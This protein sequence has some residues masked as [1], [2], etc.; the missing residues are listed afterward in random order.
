V[1]RIVVT[2]LA[3]NEQARIGAC[4]AGL[5]DQ[6]GEIHVV[7]NGSRDRTAEIARGFSGV[8]VH[9]YA[10][11]GKSR[12]WS[13]FVLDETSAY[14]DVHVFVDGDA[15]IAPG[16]V[17]ALAERLMADRHANACAGLPLNGRRAEF[18]R[19]QV[20][21]EHG[22]FGDLYALKGEFLARMKAAGI[23]LPGDLIG[24]DG[25]IGAMA[26]TDLHD[27][28]QW[29]ETRIIACPRAGWLCEPTR[30]LSP[31][32]WRIQYRRMINY[33]VRHFQNRIVSDIMRREGPTGLPRELASLYGEWLM[34]FSPRPS[35]AHWWFDRLALARMR[36][37]ARDRST[38]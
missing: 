10:E 3:H 36:A 19:A 28:T 9:D 22:I 2:V 17:A 31:A 18:Y 20:I 35:P 12:S 11:G 7:V 4:L 25:L 1:T 21:R 6:P 32:S 26:K 13:R 34:R 38:P 15:E 16:S 23:R 37:A 5:V 24:D 29:D 27:E 33:S 14:A 30:L 8:T